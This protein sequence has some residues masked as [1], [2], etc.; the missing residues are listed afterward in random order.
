MFPSRTDRQRRWII[1]LGLLGILSGLAVVADPFPRDQ[2]PTNE[3]EVLMIATLRD[4]AAAQHRFREACVLDTDGDGLG[5]FGF[6]GELAGSCRLRA[7]AFGNLSSQ[8]L[9]DPEL[10]LDFASISQRTATVHNYHVQVLLP[11]AG[12]GWVEESRDGGGAKCRIAADLAEQVFVAIAWPT[13]QTTSKRALYLTH[14]G[15]VLADVGQAD[16]P[17][18]RGMKKRPSLTDDLPTHMTDGVTALTRKGRVWVVV[19]D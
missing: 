17:E 12:G 19:P 18:L 2:A 10:P 5:E 4:L 6:L 14:Q 7:D 11:A 13:H 1:S 3:D 16:Q 9:L 15:Q 8:A